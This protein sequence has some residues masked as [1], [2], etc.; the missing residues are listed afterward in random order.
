MYKSR[1][2][3]CQREEETLKDFLCFQGS[4]KKESSPVSGMSLALERWCESPIL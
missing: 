4:I 2:L 1:M 3:V